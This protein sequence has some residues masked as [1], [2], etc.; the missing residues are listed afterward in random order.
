[1]EVGSSANSYEVVSKLAEGGMAEIFLAHV[2]GEEAL[3]RIVVIKRIVR[4][5]AH[6]VNLVKMFLDEARVATRLQH[7]NVAQVLDVGRLGSSYFLAM[8]YVHGETVRE[9]LLRARGLGRA[10]PLQTVLT[11]VAGVAGGLHHAHERGIVHADVTPSNVMV[12]REGIVKLLDF[13]IAKAADRQSRGHGG[14]QGKIAYLAPEQIR[15]TKLDR[16]T[17]LFSLGIVL[18]ELLTL[19][20]LYRRESDYQTMMAIENEP[21]PRPSARRRDLPARLEQ[22]TMRLLEKDPNRR[23]QNAGQL[24]EDVEQ[25]AAQL[26]IALSTRELGKLTNE[27]FGQKPEPQLIQTLG[28]TVRLVVRNEP[29]PNNLAET[30]SGPADE[31]FDTIRRAVVPQAKGGGKN[32]GEKD[33]LE[34]MRDR[35]FA[36][37]RSG[38]T[39]QFPRPESESPPDRPSPSYYPPAGPPPPQQQYAP[40]SSTPPQG[41]PQYPAQP[42]GYPQYPPPPQGNQL[43]PPHG[44]RHPSAPPHGYPQHPPQGRNSWLIVV[45]ILAVAFVTAIGVFLAM[46]R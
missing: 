25:L 16:R 18:Y 15:Q 1:V 27:W 45:G 41:Y 3:N 34:L 19:E 28:G 38:N 26:G 30:I 5:R 33:S 46:R 37:V 9:L 36:E 35:L 22:I 42:Q 32:D 21:P 20:G 12:S 11:I 14:V 23:Y 24:L 13:G 40:P 6:D 39:P 10:L 31:V 29:V 2:R 43:A 44:M 4:D 17:D 8:E 7:P